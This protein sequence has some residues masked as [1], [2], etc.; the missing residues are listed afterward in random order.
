MNEAYKAL[1]EMIRDR[2]EDKNIR[3]ADEVVSE[4]RTMVQFVERLGQYHDVD[5]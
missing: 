4:I 3:A 1:Y 2:V 5:A